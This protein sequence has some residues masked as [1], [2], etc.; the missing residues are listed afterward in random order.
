MSDSLLSTLPSARGLYQPLEKKSHQFRLLRIHPGQKD[1]PLN[2]D[3]FVDILKRRMGFEA[4]SYVWGDSEATKELQING[5]PFTVRENLYGALRRLRHLSKQ[6]IL[7]V[8]AICINQEDDLEK[9]HQVDMMSRIYTFATTV[10][11]WLGDVHPRQNA[12]CTDILNHLRKESDQLPMPRGTSTKEDY[13][14]VGSQIFDSP[15]FSRVWIVQESVLPRDL[16]VTIG[17]GDVSFQDMLDNSTSFIR[18]LNREGLNLRYNYFNSI[19]YMRRQKTYPSGVG[20]S[21]LK[22]IRDT[23]GRQATDPRDKVYALLGAVNDWQGYPPM[24]ADYTIG[25]RQVIVR[26]AFEIIRRQRSLEFLVAAGLFPPKKRP[27]GNPSWVANFWPGGFVQAAKRR[28]SRLSA[29]LRLIEDEILSIDASLLGT[30][31]K[32]GQVHLPGLASNDASRDNL[33]LHELGDITGVPSIVKFALLAER[34]VESKVYQEKA[35]VAYLREVFN[36]YGPLI[37]TANRKTR[38][39]LSVAKTADGADSQIWQYFEEFLMSYAKSSHCEVPSRDDESVATVRRIMNLWLCWCH[40]ARKSD[41]NP[42]PDLPGW[43][44]FTE[45]M[46]N[47]KIDRLMEYDGVTE[48]LH[49]Y[50][51]HIFRTTDSAM[52]VAGYASSGDKVYDLGGQSGLFILRQNGSRAVGSKT[53]ET[54]LLV[55]KCFEFCAPEDFDGASSKKAARGGSRLYIC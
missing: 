24:S 44:G 47:D 39:K 10:I 27:S 13:L 21:L 54:H 29:D 32:S 51:R 8:D 4:L 17:P 45:H 12:C 15:W 37:K 28:N 9:G 43:F 2:C 48:W 36:R 19:H 30:V 18:F 25:E 55:E 31:D 3:L 1:Q 46:D 33:Y 23:W 20:V 49:Y 42:P 53:V 11:A 40:L 26:A 5:Q 35:E 41:G 52:G 14:Q 7:W 34:L 16:R 38:V 6:R 22:I 50:P